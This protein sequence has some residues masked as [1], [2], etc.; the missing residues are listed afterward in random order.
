[1]PGQLVRG[2]RSPA[3]SEPSVADD[4]LDKH[5]AQIL[6]SSAANHPKNLRSSCAGRSGSDGGIMM[7]NMIPQ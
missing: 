6:K 3:E 1:M 2:T 4:S 5:K 7:R